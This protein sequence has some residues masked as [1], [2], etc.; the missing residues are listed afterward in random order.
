MSVFANAKTLVTDKPKTGKAKK[1]EV[2]LQ[3]LEDVALLE[4]L[5]QSI[6]AYKESLEAAV[7]DQ[8]R[9]IFLAKANGRRPENF[10][11]VE[12]LAEA[13]VELRKRSSRTVLS[14]DEVAVFDE[15][16]IPY[17]TIVEQAETFVL[18]PNLDA[19]TLAK[20]DKALSGIKGLPDNVIL[21]QTGVTKRVVSEATIDTVFKKGKAEEMLDTICVL[22]LK[23]KIANPNLNQAMVLAINQI[24]EGE[25]R[26][27]K[28]ARKNLMDALQASLDKKAK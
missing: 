17:D 18:N 22:A 21:K 10:R 7:K 6:G 5:L 13:S 8:A 9:E 26:A 3:G 23:P 11:A 19:A 4:A 12:G 25:D 20:I 24:T 1:P 27:S 2:P 14:E 15:H 16:N 28:T